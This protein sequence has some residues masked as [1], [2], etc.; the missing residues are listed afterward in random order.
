MVPAEAGL[1]FLCY[2]AALSLCHAGH[3]GGLSEHVF[4]WVLNVAGVQLFCVRP[5]TC[6]T[7]AFASSASLRSKYSPRTMSVMRV[8]G[9]NE[10]NMCLSIIC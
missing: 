9:G 7:C 8:M 10:S 6:P 2:M 1:N 4:D 5:E 3:I